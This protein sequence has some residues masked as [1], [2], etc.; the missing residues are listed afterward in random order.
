MCA[1]RRQAFTPAVCHRLMCMAVC[2]P[3]I[4]EY[5]TIVKVFCPRPSAFAVWLFCCLS[6]RAVWHGIQ[7]PGRGCLACIARSGLTEIR[8]MQNNVHNEFENLLTFCAICCNI[9]I[10]E[11]HRRLDEQM[12]THPGQAQRNHC[13]RTTQS[14]PESNST[15]A[16]L[17]PPTV[18]CIL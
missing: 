12:I 4:R 16:L 18:S 7:L 3:I 6:G 9:E 1:S 8:I 10:Y 17:S 11:H 5:A 15:I 14:M 2:H 13:R